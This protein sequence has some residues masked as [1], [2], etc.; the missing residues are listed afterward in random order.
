MFKK[1]LGLMLL[2]AAAKIVNCMDAGT[3]DVSAP[4]IEQYAK[5]GD[6]PFDGQNQDK[7]ESDDTANRLTRA[8]LEGNQIYIII[9]L[10]DLEKQGLINDYSD[11]L[12]SL[13]RNHN[14]D[15]VLKHL[16]TSIS[17][18]QKS[19]LAEHFAGHNNYE[20]LKLLYPNVTPNVATSV[21]VKLNN[22]SATLFAHQLTFNMPSL[23]GTP[24]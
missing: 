18:E 17:E 8:A 23:N 7:T 22:V 24:F 16:S 4:L 11:L 1:I 19:T 2:M 20:M 10:K 13:I 5:Q 3:G 6:A 12:I 14:L 15:R 21:K 9:L